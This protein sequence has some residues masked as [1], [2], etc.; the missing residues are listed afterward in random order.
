MEVNDFVKPAA[1]F[2]GKKKHLVT[3][4]PIFLLS[5]E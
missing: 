3:K 5:I 4:Q 1:F 2:R